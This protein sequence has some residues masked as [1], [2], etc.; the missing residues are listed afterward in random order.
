MTWLV[1]MIFN[2]GPAAGFCTPQEIAYHAAFPKYWDGEKTHSCK[3]KF[4]P[5]SADWPMR[6]EL[7]KQG[8][9]LTGAVRV[10]VDQQAAPDGVFKVYP[11][12]FSASPQSLYLGPEGPSQI[13]PEG[14]EASALRALR[15]LAIQEASA[16]LWPGGILAEPEGYV[17]ELDFTFMFSVRDELPFTDADGRWAP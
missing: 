14:D 2:A 11:W 5:T 1:T 4:T 10:V 16:L 6:K 9:E 7:Y 12:P 17:R 8:V 3:G 13:I 15:D